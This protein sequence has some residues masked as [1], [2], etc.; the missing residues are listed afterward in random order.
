M[1]QLS[2]EFF[3]N[4]NYNNARGQIHI[5]Q[6]QFIF[7]FY[8]SCSSFLGFFFVKTLH[9]FF[10]DTPSHCIKTPFTIFH[11]FWHPQDKSSHSGFSLK[12]NTPSA[13]LPF[14]VYMLNFF[15]SIYC[16]WLHHLVLLQSPPAHAQ[17]YKGS[18]AFLYWHQAHV[19]STICNGG[20]RNYIKKGQF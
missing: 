7:L 5:I 18:I 2:D 1:T 20:A 17:S 4:F 15:P 14:C 3:G 11:K 19:S 10:G 16:I 9:P 8:F 6:S 13:K 12:W